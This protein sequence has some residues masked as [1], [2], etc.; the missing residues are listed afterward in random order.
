MFNISNKSRRNILI[1]I[2]FVFFLVAGWYFY[3]P[4]WMLNRKVK[5]VESLLENN[6]TFEG[7][8]VAIEATGASLERYQKL[9]EPVQQSLQKAVPVARERQ[10]F[11]SSIYTCTFS[12][13]GKYFVTG[14]KDGT[15]RFW[16]P[17]GTPLEKSIQPWKVTNKKSA[18]IGITF[19]AKSQKLLISNR[20]KKMQIWDV[21]GRPVSKPW[22]GILAG[23][24]AFSPDGKIIVAAG[25]NGKVGVWDNQGN[26][27]RSPKQ[28]HWVP[29]TDIAFHP[30]GQMFITGDNLG[31]ILR[32]TP[33]GKQLNK[34]EKGRN[35]N[36]AYLVFRPD[37]ESF[38]AFKTLF[39]PS[40]E[41]HFW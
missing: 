19:D 33:T 40:L 3:Y 14:H 21:K 39:P 8:L 22:S 17:D 16:K 34:L 36:S 25:E 41:E 27:L 12:P 9:I 26:V 24:L 11:E 6:Q 32:W 2:G 10:E 5:E 30:D 29:V 4:R 15:V 28:A 23:K 31:R 35:D 1:L 37:G 18:I 13:D 38:L 7:L 20:D